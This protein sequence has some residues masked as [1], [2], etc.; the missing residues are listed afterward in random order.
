MTDTHAHLDFPQFDADR[1]ETIDRA[2]S[3]GVKK[4]IN[5]GCDLDRSV[6]SVALSREFEPVYA[7]VG[8]HPNEFNGENETE[9]SL[10]KLLEKLEDLT[11]LPKVVAIGETGLDYYR[12]KNAEIEKT[13]KRQLDA[14]IGQIELA[15]KKSLPVIIHCREAYEDALQ[16]VLEYPTVEFV[17]HCYGGTLDFTRQALA[18]GNIR[19][20]FSGNITYPPRASVPAEAEM[21]DV[22]KLIPLSKIMLDSD[23]PFLAPVPFRGKR[24]E[25]LYVQKIA[26]HISEIKQVPR[27]LVERETDR[28][29]ADFFRF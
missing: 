1:A 14:F 27:E 15:R 8:I 24:N 29:A 20:S 17:F 10:E 18:C 25:P 3:G 26:Q 12:I 22:V 19:F 13:K 4:I 7:A 2:V 16:A 11:A 6:S 5:V 28:T 21:A 23:C 9:S